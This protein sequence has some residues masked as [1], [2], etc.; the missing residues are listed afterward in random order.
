MNSSKRQTGVSLIE[1]LVTTLVLGIG[2]L[3]VAALQV[4]SVSSNQEGFFTSQAT[5]IAQDYASRVRTSGRMITAVPESDPATTS[6]TQH[7][8]YLATYATGGELACGGAPANMCRS[9]N[10][11]TPA[12]CDEATM[13]AFDQWEI[14][15]IA[16]NTLP[17]GKV[18]AIQNAN[19]LTIVVDWDSA[20]E[21]GDLGTKKNVNS[22]CQGLIGNA[23]RNCVIVEL[24]P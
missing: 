4:S 21:R 10:G 16:K 6:I 19:R 9:D 13:K 2:L 12:S 8:N 15:D 23:D 11:T 17:D 5:S 24:V 7:L 18:R 14:C 1:I 20:S 3:G 22:N